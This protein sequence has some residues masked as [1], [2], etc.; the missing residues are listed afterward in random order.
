MSALSTDP[1]VKEQASTETLPWRFDTTP[2]LTTGE[3]PSAAIASL[4]DDRSGVAYPAGL[5]GDAQVSG[6]FITQSVT[7]LQR[8]RT[9][10]LVVTFQAAVG[11]VWSMEL[12]LTCP[13]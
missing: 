11:K 2:L 6:N 5:T 12:I 9:Y 10:R 4:T 13:F 7:A 1:P 8:G 3:S